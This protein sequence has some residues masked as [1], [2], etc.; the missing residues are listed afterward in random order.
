MPTSQQSWIKFLY[1]SVIGWIWIAAS[2]VAV[3]FLVR[4]VFFGDGWWRFIASVAVAWFL[5][6]VTLYYQ[7]EKPV[8]FQ[9]SNIPS[10][11]FEHA[12]I[13]HGLSIEERPWHLN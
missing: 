7:L 6:K 4:V 8:S 1:V 2:L 12:L 13:E 9:T 11:C 3:Y 5:Y 10:T